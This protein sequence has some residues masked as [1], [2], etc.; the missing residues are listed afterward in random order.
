[1]KGSG[2]KSTFSGKIPTNSAVP[3]SLL[4]VHV[5]SPFS[6]PAPHTSWSEDGQ[7]LESHAVSGLSSSC[8]WR[9]CFAQPLT[10]G[11]MGALS[12]VLLAD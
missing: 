5:S 7:K 10:A 4:H 8:S 1:M 9:E 6:S 2:N 12:K 11:V 3:S